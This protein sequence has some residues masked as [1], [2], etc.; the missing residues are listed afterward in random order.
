MFCSWTSKSFDRWRP[1]QGRDMRKYRSRHLVANHKKDFD[2][3]TNLDINIVN[4]N[5]D[6][7][8]GQVP[9]CADWDENKNILSID[10]SGQIHQ[11]GG[12]HKGN[13]KQDGTEWL[14][15]WHRGWS[16]AKYFCFH[17]KIFGL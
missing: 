16:G 8:F 13:P 2:S 14:H 10:L 9:E 7:N 4:V 3:K 6:I 12:A 17:A 11:K 5:I 1:A 15:L